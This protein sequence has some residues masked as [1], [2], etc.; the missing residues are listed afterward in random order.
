MVKATMY[1][2]GAEALLLRTTFLGIEVIAKVRVRKPYRSRELDEALRRRRTEVEAKIISQLRLAGVPVPAVLYVDPSDGLIL[3][4]YVEGPLLKELIKEDSLGRARK[5]V[6]ALG[7]YVALMHGLGIAHGDLT[8]SNVIIF[9][10]TPYIIDFGL[11]RF[12]TKMEDFGTDIH[13]FIR[14]LE[15]AHFR[16]KEVLL[17]SFLKGYSSVAGRERSRELMDIVK[18]IRMRGRYVEERRKVGG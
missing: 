2:L 12:T 16:F 9:R 18:E 14:V 11:S 13:L 10:D 4:E 15:S 6:E 17:R 3:L 5:Y 7:R 8:T 1:A